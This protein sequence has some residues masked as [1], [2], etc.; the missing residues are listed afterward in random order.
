[1]AVLF[2]LIFAVLTPFQWGRDLLVK[3]PKW[4]SFGHIVEAG[5]DR[6]VIKKGSFVQT[7]VVKGWGPNQKKHPDDDVN[8]VEPPNER[9]VMRLKGPEPCYP[10]TSANLV[11]SAYTVIK[12][13]DKMPESGGAFAPG[14]AFGDTGIYDRLKEHGFDMYTVGHLVY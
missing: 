14:A 6:E 11:A 9:L 8:D 12:E 4:L 3:Y 7:Y 1:M 13:S 10:G 5:P 2:G